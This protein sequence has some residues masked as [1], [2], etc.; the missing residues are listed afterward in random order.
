MYPS[1]GGSGARAA[2]RAAQRACLACARLARRL[3][4]PR[5]AGCV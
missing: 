3:R 2:W 5:P 1:G 4:A